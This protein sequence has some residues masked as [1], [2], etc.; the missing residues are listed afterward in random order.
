[1]L[2]PELLDTS[3]VEGQRRECNRVFPMNHWCFGRT[4]NLGWLTEPEDRHVVRRSAQKG[5]KKQQ[6]GSEVTS[7]P[8][9]CAS[10][11]PVGDLDLVL[12]DQELN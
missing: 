6:A 9:F 5:A 10:C 4:K 7:S 3:E 1:M 12:I 8:A 11:I 2:F